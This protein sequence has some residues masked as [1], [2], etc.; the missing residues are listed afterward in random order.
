MVPS[1]SAWKISPACRICVGDAELLHDVGAQ[2]EEA[3]LQALEVVGGLDL[4]AEPA[5]GL[6][7][8]QAAGGG[9]DV[10]LGVQLVIELAA[11]A[12]VHPAHV[13]ARLRA[14]RHGRVHGKGD[15]LAREEAAHRPGRVERAVGDRIEIL[16]RRHQCAGLEEA[17]VDRAAGNLVHRIDEVLL[18]GTQ[19]AGRGW[20]GSCDLQTDFLVLSLGCVR[21]EH[22]RGRRNRG[23]PG[24]QKH[25]VESPGVSCDAA[26]CWT[27]SFVRD[28]QTSLHKAQSLPEGARCRVAPLG[29]HGFHA[30]RSR[31]F[32]RA[33]R[34]RRPAGVGPS[35]ATR[36]CT[37]GR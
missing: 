16:A 5:G 2:A 1:C 8:D 26:R 27:C 33:W 32:C 22:E 10:V 6:G 23:E 31:A 29:A 18:G 4:L 28:E 14:E 3:H 34:R 36:A 15:V 30:I 19:Q 37:R 9:D 11:A 21:H 12:V 20:K 7:R 13:L 17:G 35:R 24:F 25:D